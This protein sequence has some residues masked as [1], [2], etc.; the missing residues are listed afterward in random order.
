MPEL[1]YQGCSENMRTSVLLPFHMQLPTHIIHDQNYILL[2]I[3]RSAN[4]SKRRVYRQS[5]KHLNKAGFRAT[6]DSKLEEHRS[7]INLLLLEGDKPGHIF[8]W[9]QKSFSK[10]CISCSTF[11]SWVSQFREGRE[12]VRDKPSQGSMLR[13]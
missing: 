11:Y 1:T 5:Y 8:Q 3:N 6:M 4:F 10:A 7:V 13:Q 2:P 9:L 12:S